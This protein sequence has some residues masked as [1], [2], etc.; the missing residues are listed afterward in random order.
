V[1]GRIISPCSFATRNKREKEWDL[2][3]YDYEKSITTNTYYEEVVG[4]REVIFHSTS[5]I[6][7]SKGGEGEGYESG[8]EFTGKSASV[9]KSL[10]VSEGTTAPRKG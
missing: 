1:R 2:G 6:L 4:R 9:S 8:G 5:D 7:S 10:K 3:S